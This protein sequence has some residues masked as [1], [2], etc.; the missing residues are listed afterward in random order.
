MKPV[1]HPSVNGLINK[2]RALASVEMQ[3]L[4]ASDGKQPNAKL[5]LRRRWCW[6]HPRT[7]LIMKNLPEARYEHVVITA[8]QVS[9]TFVFLSCGMQ[10]HQLDSVVPASEGTLLPSLRAARGGTAMST[11]SELSTPAKV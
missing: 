6:V 3:M 5:D 10:T 4:R 8:R 9:A 7:D 1:L 2:G 11:P